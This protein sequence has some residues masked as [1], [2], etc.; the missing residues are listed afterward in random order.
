[1]SVEIANIRETLFTRGLHAKKNY[2]QH[3]LADNRVLERI[4]SASE[5]GSQ[6]FVIEIGAGLGALTKEL[7]KRAGFVLAYEIDGD[8]L[9]ILSDVLREH[10]NF[11]I[12]NEDILKA[13]LPAE[14]EN[15]DVKTC[16]IVANL[17]YYITTPFIF[18]VFETALPV[19]EMVLMVQKEVADR[20]VSS[21]A[22]K[23]YGALTANA[24][25]YSDISLVC[26]V[27]KNCFVPRPDIDSAVIK[28][29]LKAPDTT[30]DKDLLFSIIKAAFSKRRKTL[31][32]CLCDLNGEASK[33]K[34]AEVIVNTGFNSDIRGEVLGIADF[35]KLSHE[36]KRA[37]Q[38]K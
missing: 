5:V 28:M 11:E 14:L 13:D 31:V 9:P 3:F 29:K 10:N 6:D 8:M 25:F 38:N 7:C 19:S 35:L 32:N 37:F 36:W 2:G 34:I 26:N 24:N 21:P 16:K 22:T 12:K 27:P 1:M 4:I 30:V 23:E 17:P 15:R 20:L 18:K 33:E